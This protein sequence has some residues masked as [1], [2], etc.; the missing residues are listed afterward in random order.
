V[1]RKALGRSL[2]PLLS[3]LFF[4]VGDSGRQVFTKA[5]IAYVALIRDTDTDT[6]YVDTPIR[7]FSKNTDT[8]ISNIY[9]K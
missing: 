4:H 6:R 3:F 7:H 9:Y 2:F 8:T 5:A 1:S